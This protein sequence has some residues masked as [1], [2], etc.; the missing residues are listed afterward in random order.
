MDVFAFYSACVIKYPTR[1][2]GSVKP[3]LFTR[4]QIRSAYCRTGNFATSFILA[5][6]HCQPVSDVLFSRYAAILLA[7]HKCTTCLNGLRT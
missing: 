2:A 3:S 4:L 1:N 7:D 5:F 6:S